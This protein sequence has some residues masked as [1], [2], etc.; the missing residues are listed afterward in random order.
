MVTRRVLAFA[1]LFLPAAHLSAQ[2][3]CPRVA[4]SHPASDPRFLASPDDMFAHTDFFQSASFPSD[5]FQPLSFQPA[6]MES[7]FFQSEPSGPSEPAPTVSSSGLSIAVADF[8]GA[9]KEL[10]R[11]LADTLLTDL[12][13]SERLHMVER[14]EIGK[15]LT[16]LKLQSTGLA[17][18]QDVKKVGRLLGADRL[19]VGSYLVREGQLLINA[20]LLDV[21][22][23]RV[24]PGGAA[25]V[26]GN[27]DQMLLL[28]HQLAHRFHRRVTG[29]DLLLENERV[30]PALPSRSQTRPNDTGDDTLPNPALTSNDRPDGD[31]T[32]NTRAGEA[33]GRDN[34]L[35]S[36][37]G[38]NV[39]QPEQAGSSAAPAFNPAFNSVPPYIVV[40]TVYAP[41]RVVLTGDMT[42]LLNRSGGRDAGR[43]FTPGRDGSPVS[44]LRVLVA[45]VRAGGF[46]IPSAA[47]NAGSLNGLLPD[48]MRVPMWAAPYVSVALHNGLVPLYRP[49]SPDAD[50]DWGFVGAVAHRLNGIAQLARRGAGSGSGGRAVPGVAARA[51]DTITPRVTPATLPSRSGGGLEVRPTLAAQII[52][53]GLLIEARD[54]PVQRTM[55]ARIVDTDGQQVYPDPQHVPDI[56]YVEDHG[57][58]DYYHSGADANRAGLHPLVVRAL[59]VSGDAIVVS[60]QTAARIREEERRDG[61]LRLWRVGIL[62]DEGR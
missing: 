5:P 4:P 11:F 43:F 15:A 41:Q 33:M 50:A 38:Y 54:L 6:S 39:R 60:A 56:D 30:E 8:S 19:I 16:E 35:P 37:N 32:N 28:V 58:A 27:R 26:T 34:A 12:T 57:M 53:T 31:R 10:G 59:S 20:R 17:E 2:P 22:T 9:D 55:S 14:A 36:R 25:N 46:V 24:T 1:L 48:A 44:R 47:G 49:L 18:P 52:Y 29:A 21:R 62:L 7:L 40:P 42:R 23:G 45:L 51:R 13:Q 3:S 61:F